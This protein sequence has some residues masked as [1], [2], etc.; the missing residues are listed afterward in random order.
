MLFLQF[1]LKVND[2]QTKKKRLPTWNAFK[3]EPFPSLFFE[4]DYKSFKAVSFSLPDKVLSTIEII[5]F[6]VTAPVKQL[7]ADGA[8]KT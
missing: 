4:H 2:I 8:L 3:I 6:D 7:P 1:F 5:V